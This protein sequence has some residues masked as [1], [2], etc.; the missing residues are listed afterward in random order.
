MR[1][2]KAVRKYIEALPKSETKTEA[3]LKAGYSTKTTTGQIERSKTFKTFQQNLSKQIPDNLTI[4]AFKGA[5]LAV[6]QR[7][8]ISDGE[9]IDTIIED[10]HYIRLASAKEVCKLKG[11]Y[12]QLEGNNPNPID[13]VEFGW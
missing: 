6:K 13:G 5:L 10:D 7:P 8:I 4:K 9:I 11:Q 1:G 2:K 12:S 3:K